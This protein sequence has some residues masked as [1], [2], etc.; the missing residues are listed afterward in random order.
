MASMGA[1]FDSTEYVQNAKFRVLKG[2]APHVEG[3]WLPRLHGRPIEQYELSGPDR[4]PLK[5]IIEVIRS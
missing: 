1:F 3:Y 4:K 5:V 2:K